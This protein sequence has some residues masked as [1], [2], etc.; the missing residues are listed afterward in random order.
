MG[1]VSE[2]LAVNSRKPIFGYMAMVGSLFAIAFLRFLFG[3]IIC[4]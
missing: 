2:V 1:M 4:L 3:R